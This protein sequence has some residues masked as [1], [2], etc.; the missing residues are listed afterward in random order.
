M[1]IQ[2]RIIFFRMA[3]FLI[4]KILVYIKVYSLD[5]RVLDHSGTCYNA[6]N[7]MLL[8]FIAFFRPQPI[9]VRRGE[10]PERGRY[11]DILLLYYLG[12]YAD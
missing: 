4:L 9:A 8:Y 3:R 12:I 2:F 10:R 11:F 6:L 1:S 7:Y 5:M